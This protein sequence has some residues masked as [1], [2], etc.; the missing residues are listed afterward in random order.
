MSKPTPFYEC[1]DSGSSAAFS[2]HTGVAWPLHNAS[3]NAP[4]AA[5]SDPHVPGVEGDPTRLS[6]SGFAC[7][8][9]LG[10]RGRLP[11]HLDAHRCSHRL[12]GMSAPFVQE[13]GNGAGRTPTSTDT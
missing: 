7:P 10:H 2:A 4:E 13:S 12:D 3:G 5:D 8:L 6:G 11:V 1:S 9:W